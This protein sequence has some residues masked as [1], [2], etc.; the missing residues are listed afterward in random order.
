M[1]VGSR[2]DRRRWGDVNVEYVEL[3]VIYDGSDGKVFC[4]GIVR[5]KMVRRKVEEFD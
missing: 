3:V 4:G 1:R 2:M 5:E